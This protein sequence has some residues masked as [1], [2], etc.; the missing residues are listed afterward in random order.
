MYDNSKTRM[1]NI[2]KTRVDFKKLRRF[3]QFALEKGAIRTKIIPVKTIVA[4]PWVK[5]KCQYWCKNYGKSKV[6]PPN[7]PKYDETKAVIN[8]YEKAIL[9]HGNDKATVTK[10]ALE[11]EK[12][13]FL[14][15]CYK[16]FAYGAGP[17]KLSPEDDSIDSG[18]NIE[19]E[20]PLLDA[21]GIDVFQT[22]R[23]N[24]FRIDIL[25]SPEIRPNYFSL[26]LIE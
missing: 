1:H 25:Y 13:A 3:S 18:E 14:S 9:I 6:C 12:E 19:Q 26:V 22:A 24:G 8:Y 11:T 20:R 2:S 7:S 23:N 5:L 17:C 10:I 4:A 21:V 15:G 16:A